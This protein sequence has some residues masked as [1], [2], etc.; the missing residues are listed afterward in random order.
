MSEH[1]PGYEA[2]DDAWKLLDKIRH[3][4]NDGFDART[5]EE[6]DK[7]FARLLDWY[8]SNAKTLP[9]DKTLW[10]HSWALEIIA[11]ETDLK[12]SRTP[13]EIPDA[14]NKR[15]L[16]SGNHFKTKYKEVQNLVLR[17]E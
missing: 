8:R 16:G 12:F 2:D 11:E 13:D 9:K 17:K 3:E 7:F 1:Y 14:E 10:A 5:A 15:K 4:F 6:T